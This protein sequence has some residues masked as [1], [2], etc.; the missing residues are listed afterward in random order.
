MYTNELI[1]EQVTLRVTN[2]GS[3]EVVSSNTSRFGIG[4]NIPQ[5]NL[6]TLLKEGVKVVLGGLSQTNRF[7][8]NVNNAPQNGALLLG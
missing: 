6:N 2:D 4:T 8:E 5:S 1:S 3:Y 7:D